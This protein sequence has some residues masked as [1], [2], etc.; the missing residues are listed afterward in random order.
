MTNNQI[1]YLKVQEDRRHNVASEGTEARKAGA[2]ESQASAAHRQVGVGYANVAE[3]TRHNKATET[4]GWY[5]AEGRVTAQQQQ[6][7]AATTQAQ[8][9]INSAQAA[10]RR[11]EV[12]RKRNEELTRH[13]QALEDIQRSGVDVQSRTAAENER[14]NR[15]MESLRSYELVEGTVKDIVQ[16]LVPYFFEE[17]NERG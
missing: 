12:E 9:S 15:S 2:A 8:A 4:L 6:A 11:V 1:A 13:N 3:L 7:A 10:M 17:A 14:H 16:Y 5:D